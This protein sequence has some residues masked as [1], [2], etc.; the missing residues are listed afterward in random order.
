MKGGAQKT[1]K[2]DHRKRKCG[3]RAET[4]LEGAGHDVKS[5][6]SPKEVLAVAA[7]GEVI[8][9]AVPFGEIDESLSMMG[10]AVNPTTCNPPAPAGG[11]STRK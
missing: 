3:N 6:N 7:R 8:T 10:D 11:G 1:E 2:R 5:G 9:L 4:P